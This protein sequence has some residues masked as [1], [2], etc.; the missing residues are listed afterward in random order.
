MTWQCFG[1]VF[2]LLSP[3]H[4]GFHKVGSVQRTRHYIPARNLL[5]STAELLVHSGSL[6][7]PY[8]DALAWVRQHFCFSY[9]F[10]S[11][12]QEVLLPTYTNKGLRYG[13]LTRDEFE[14]RYLSAHVTTAMDA[15]TTSAEQ[16]SLHEVEFISPHALDQPGN[17]K[18][19]QIGGWI[20][21]RQDVWNLV[22][23]EAALRNHLAEL[24]VGGE[25]RY[26]FGWLSLRAANWRPTTDMCGWPLRLDAS[27]P[28]VGLAMGR[29]FLAHV[30]A[31]GVRARGMIEPLV[32][33]ETQGDSGQ[34]GRRL[35]PGRIC[36]APG[37]VCEDA[38]ALQFAEDGTCVAAGGA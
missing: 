27:R 22:G 16:G 26:S 7:L 5:A 23:D 17:P 21:V 10:I 13:R 35:T 34:F 20:F 4:I 25:R 1:I 9:F 14:R 29:S 37:S 12:G 32:G 18:R 3:L 36:W 31:S 8:Q 15:E 30:P 24:Q 38:T 2:D 33:R 28:E 19:T 11:E 6:R